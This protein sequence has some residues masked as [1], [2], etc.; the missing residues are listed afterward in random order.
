ML[1]I[2]RPVPTRGPKHPTA[3]GT[4]TQAMTVPSVVRNGDMAFSITTV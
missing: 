4:L 2:V 3:V 1:P